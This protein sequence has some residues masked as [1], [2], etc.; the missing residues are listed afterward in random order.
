MRISYEGNQ[1]I[2]MIEGTPRPSYYFIDPNIYSATENT[3]ST[4]VQKN[5]TQKPKKSRLE[6]IAAGD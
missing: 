6:K 4:I 2:N 1:A 3:I 5:L